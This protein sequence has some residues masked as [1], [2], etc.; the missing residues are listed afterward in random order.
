MMVRHKLYNF[1]K[2][3]CLFVIACFVLMSS[4]TVVTNSE[5][6]GYLKYYDKAHEIINEIDQILIKKG[7]CTDISDCQKKQIRFAGWESWGITIETYSIKDHHVLNELV[8]IC[9]K[10]FFES[11]EQFEIKIFIYPLSKQDVIATPF[12]NEPKPTKIIMKG[13][14]NN[15]KR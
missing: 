7:M 1:I 10:H 15:V 3:L 14:G 13:G 5:A 6:T 2:L 9:S 4:L 12:W 8:K 11:K